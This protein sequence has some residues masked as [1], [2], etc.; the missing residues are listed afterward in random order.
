MLSLEGWHGGGM[1][2]FLGRWWRWRGGE[3][4]FS[5]VRVT[6]SPGKREEMLRKGA[7]NCLIKNTHRVSGP[8]SVGNEGKLESPSQS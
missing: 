8:A 5:M 3:T 1:T 7:E 2:G 4:G 6:G